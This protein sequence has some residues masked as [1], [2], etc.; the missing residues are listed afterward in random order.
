ML[1]DP[2]RRELEAR[3]DEA[4]GPAQASQR[5]RGKRLATKPSDLELYERRTWYKF[6]KGAG[7]SDNLPPQSTP[8]EQVRLA[9]AF[10]FFRLVHFHGGAH[11]YLTWYTW[12]ELPIVMMSPVIHLREGGDFAFGARWAL[13]QYHA[14]ED[15]RTFLDI[16]DDRIKEVFRSWID[17]TACPWY[18]KEQYLKENSRRLRGVGGAKDRATGWDNLDAAAGQDARG[19]DRATGQDN[20]DGATGQ[21]EPTSAEDEPLELDESETEE[22]GDTE[23]G[24]AGDNDL[25][26]LRML[27]RG[28]MEEVCRREE[29]YRH[30]RVINRKH[31]FS[32]KKGVFLS[33]PPPIDKITPG[34]PQ[35]G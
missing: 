9:N 19:A 4:A 22:P 27:Y 17:G 13:V 20:L 15:R 29:Q 16:P 26:V 28:N 34:V 12:D 24:R 3:G 33:M 25:H 30:A 23:E 11:P 21:D 5:T 14:W 7:S 2:V 6:Q 35:G 32:L 1:N 18:I 8:E 31:T 10:D